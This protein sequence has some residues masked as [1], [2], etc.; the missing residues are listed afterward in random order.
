MNEEIVK[1]Y[2][3]TNKF[4]KLLDMQY[5]L[6]ATGDIIYDVTITEK[7]LATKTAAHGGL[8]A[9]MMDGVVGVAALEEASKNG[10]LV[11]TVEMKLNFLQ[12]AFLNDRLKGVGKILKAGK[13]IIVVEGKIYNQDNLLLAVGIATMN[14]YPIEKSDM[15]K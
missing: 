1:R 15:F 11:S 6:D 2:S 7:H 13:R 8:L 5:R 9:A 3:Q 10:N 12:P 14:A 4:G